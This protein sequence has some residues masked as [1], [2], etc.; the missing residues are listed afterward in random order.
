MKINNICKNILKITEE[1]VEELRDSFDEQVNYIHPLKHAT[2][3]KYNKLG[4]YNHKV[5]DKMLELKELIKGG[6]ELPIN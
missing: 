5:L 6:K 1:E 2:A 3:K 4:S